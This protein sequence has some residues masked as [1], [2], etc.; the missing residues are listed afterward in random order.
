M[1]RLG[2]SCGWATLGSAGRALQDG[3]GEN[4]QKR[5][6]KKRRKNF[7]VENTHPHVQPSSES[8]LESHGPAK[9]GDRGGWWHVP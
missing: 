5:A 7:S 2:L 1:P 4:W 9:C 3:L 6:P 8:R